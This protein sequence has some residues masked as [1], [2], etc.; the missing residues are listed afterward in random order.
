MLFAR[1]HASGRVDVVRSG[2]TFNARSR[3][4]QEFT[5][6]LSPETIAGRCYWTVEARADGRVW[7][8]FYVTPD[9][10]R[11]VSETGDRPPAAGR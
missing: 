6:L 3:G 4:V 1:D 9:G 7:R 2:N 5:L 11:L 10:Q 8:R